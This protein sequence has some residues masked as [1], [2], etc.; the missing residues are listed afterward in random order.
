MK[1]KCDVEHLHDEIESIFD[2]EIITLGL[3]HSLLDHF[4]VEEVI[5]ETEKEVQLADDD[6]YESSSRWVLRKQTKERFEEHDRGGER[7]SELVGDGRCVT[8][9]S[10]RAIALLDNL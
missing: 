2:I 6:F 4:D 9:H 8:L 5:D 10:V 3:E 1:V 7:R